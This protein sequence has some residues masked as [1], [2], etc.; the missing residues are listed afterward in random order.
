MSEA[1]ALHT[2]DAAVQRLLDAVTVLG[3][4]DAQSMRSGEDV[5]TRL[6]ELVEELSSEM[7]ARA[8]AQEEIRSLLR[9]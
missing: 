5:G 2:R 8:A 4:L 7:T 3:Q 6:T 9:T 1:Q